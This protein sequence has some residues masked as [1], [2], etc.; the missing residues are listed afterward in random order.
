MAGFQQ[1]GFQHGPTGNAWRGFA[2]HAKPA[3]KYI[4][5]MCIYGN[6][7]AKHGILNRKT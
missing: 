1:A 3:F 4:C 7:M 6:V 2:I 5:M